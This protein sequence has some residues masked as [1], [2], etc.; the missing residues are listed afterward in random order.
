MFKRLRRQNTCLFHLCWI[1]L[2]CGSMW[3]AYFW[4]VKNA[5]QTVHF[6]LSARLLVIQYYALFLTFRWIC[7]C[8]NTA[9]IWNVFLLL[10]VQHFVQS[11]YFIYII[12]LCLC[13]MCFNLHMLRILKVIITGSI[14]LVI[15]GRLYHCISH[16]SSP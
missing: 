4:I 13:E 14:F 5:E 1:Y 11:L 15:Y 2:L 16:H 7:K 3:F 8:Y 12:I 9:C 10:T 6:K